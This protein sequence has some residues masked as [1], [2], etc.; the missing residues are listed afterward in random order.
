MKAH[1][2]KIAVCGQF[3]RAGKTHLN[4][5]QARRFRAL[6]P[7]VGSS[8][9]RNLWNSLLLSGLLLGILLHADTAC[10]TTRTVTSLS[11]S[12]PGTLRDTIAASAAGDTIIFSV[13]GELLLT[14]GE[15][16]VSRDLS[17]VGP[18]AKLL[19]VNGN[20]ASR[21]FGI[22][23]GTVK[24]SGLSLGAGTSQSNGGC[25]A[26][27]A[28]LTISNCTI[29]GDFAGGY[30]GGGIFNLGTLTVIDCTISGNVANIGG[31]I[32]NRGNLT[33][34]NST[35]YGNAANGDA[36]IG[37]GIY[38]AGTLTINN[39]TIS[40]NVGYQ[41]GGGIYIT[42]GTLSV[43]NSIIAF[44][45]TPNGTT[46][47]CDAFGAVSSQGHNLVGATDGSSG[48]LDS[49]LTGTVA[50]PLDPLLG[51]LQDNGGPTRTTYLL[52]G[53]A[54]I[55]AGDDSVLGPPL[56]LTTDQRDYPRRLGAHV[57]IGAV[58]IGQAPAWL[59]GTNM[60]VPNGSGNFGQLPRGPGVWGGNFVF[61]GAG[62][63]FQQGIYG[64]HPPDP[65]F[66]TDPW[67]I[68][69]LNTPIPGGTGNFLRFSGLGGTP[70][71]YPS[72][73]IVPVDPIVSG[74]HV[75]FAGFGD[76]NQQGI[77]AFP[78]DPQHPV[79]PQK[80]VDLNTPIPPDGVNNF[81]LFITDSLWPPDPC[82]SGNTVAF[83][84]AGPNTMGIYTATLDGAL[85][86]IADT[87]TLTPGNTEGDHFISFYTYRPDPFISGNNVVFSAYSSNGSNS[88]TPGVYLSTAGALS[89]V[90][91][92]TMG[93][94]EGTGNFS[95]FER[96]DNFPGSPQVSSGNVLFWAHTTDGNEGLYLKW[97]S[98][99]MKIIANTQTPI[100]GGSG[101]FTG[102]TSMSLSV[103]TVA[104]VGLGSG[105]QMGIYV[106]H[107]QDPLYPV[108]PMYKV[109]D[110]NDMLDGKTLT[111][112]NLSRTGL[113]RDH[114]LLAFGATFSDGT[115]ALYTLNVF[116]GLR[117][118]SLARAAAD[119]QLTFT[120][121]VGNSYTVQS[122]ADLASGSWSNLLTQIPG[123]P[124]L[125][126]TII[127]SN[128]CAAPQQFFRIEQEQ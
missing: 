90:A 34:N 12:G 21:V 64:M 84:G 1:H 72:D 86:R 92:N 82:I 28:S 16:A 10:A 23:S 47:T 78:V 88:T 122:R 36:A 111:G 61:F 128:A 75:V 22:Y 125:T 85:T 56:N 113:D 39:S 91:D 46:P 26:N 95:Q 69:D 11:D 116:T 102:F 94:P 50:A 89:R 18:G 54:A 49:D 121:Q 104:F 83:Y 117:I 73:P 107:P 100:P 41:Q 60:S 120:S 14:S 74:N 45:F 3:I 30:E 43:I 55:N 24:I 51:P 79:D 53:S 115:Q 101:N 5:P 126:Q 108:D 9:I 105:G 15:L 57:D 48:W 62:P 2:E 97:P 77:Y 98:D 4:L 42:N 25:I 19:S 124:S 96:L 81:G 6:V 87:T 8:F 7:G 123:S 65:I 80:I 44:N 103:D 58:E 29:S 31:G 70:G 76:N 71:G 67:K 66:P 13:S 114:N 40:R 33:V 127:L 68:V 32:A 109:I 112:L 17:I 35:I 110:L 63:D 27:L 59:T 118:T 99:P 106:A 37:G 93:N 119:L 52:P 20:E 38:D